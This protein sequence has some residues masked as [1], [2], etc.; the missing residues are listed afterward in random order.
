MR[1]GMMY[2]TTSL[3]GSVSVLWRR[4]C[5]LGH[6]GQQPERYRLNGWVRDGW[7]AADTVTIFSALFDDLGVG[8]VWEFD[9][10]PTANS[11]SNLL[12]QDFAAGDTCR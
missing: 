11:V 12:D 1:P 3:F 10:T 4:I 5:I 9:D 7:A 8:Y 6:G 2:G